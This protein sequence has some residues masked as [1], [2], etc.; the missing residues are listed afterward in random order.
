[1]YIS[2]VKLI[3]F[4]N[5]KNA[6]INFSETS[7]IIGSNDVGKSNL[8]HA[9]RILL[10]RSLSEVDVEPSDSDFYVHESTNQLQITVHFKDVDEDCVLA[11]M[12]EYVSDD[13]NLFLSYR[14]SKDI[15]SGRKEY[16]FYAGYSE[17]NLVGIE[18]RF[19]LRV[20]NLKFVASKR[21]L[22]MFIN[23]ERRQL[24]QDAKGKC[25][26]E[27]SIQDGKKLRKIEKSLGVVSK[28]INSLF[29]IGLATSDLN[30]Q[31]NLLSHHNSNYN[32]IFDAGQSNPSEFIDN[33]DL[34]AQVN[35]K[36]LLV[37]GDGR[38][39]QIQMALWAA[40]NNVASAAERTEF[41]I[42]C[43][44]EPET[45]LHPHQQRKLAQYL[46][47]VL[48]TQVIIT[49]HSPQ[50]ACQVPPSSII[51]L[52]EGSPGTLAAGN[53]INPFTESSIIEFGYRLNIIPAEAFFA[54]VVLLVEGPSE[55]LFYKALAK[56]LEI[57][58]D[59]LNISVLMVNGVGFL[60]YVSLLKS[61]N[62]KYV[63]RT[64]NDIFKVPRQTTYRYAGLQRGL[65][66]AR[67]THS[68][69]E[70][71]PRTVAYEPKLKGF[72]DAENVPL[73][74]KKAAEVLRRMLKAINIFVADVDLEHDLYTEMPD[75]LTD[76]S[77]KDADEKVLKQM[78]KRKATFMFDFLQS[79]SDALSMLKDSNLAQP[80]RRCEEL[81]TV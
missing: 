48:N 12:R 34:S 35:G 61:L 73:E 52:Y 33:L 72:D 19:Y 59:R 78:Q 29:Y 56:A 6:T 50:I 41:S 81:V 54:G 8:L 26:E 15:A 24:L 10:D 14:A 68:I 31:L 44:E 75:I 62:I 69:D 53:G 66:I 77:C 74:N 39:N 9:L 63:V 37:G 79:H 67:V 25:K 13:A 23:R 64:D 46:S 55:E 22:N 80:L 11:K 30:E 71:C 36:S 17:E 49:T 45:H 3:G 51:R 7:L 60:P 32:I 65:E 27:E 76:Y 57:D 43:I 16:G 2:C 21:D 5:F 58:L 4:R 20:L 18:T 38:N 40:R 1:M 70:K 47:D 28:R 42:F